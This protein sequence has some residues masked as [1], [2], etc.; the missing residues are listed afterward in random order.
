MRAEQEH[1][2]GGHE[3]GG[4]KLGGEADVLSEKT[5]LF[6]PDEF[7]DVISVDSFIE[8]INSTA[9]ELSDEDCPLEDGALDNFYQF[10]KECFNGFFEL[11]DQKQEGDQFLLEFSKSL[12]VL[13]RTFLYK[14]GNYKLDNPGLLT[15]ITDKVN[16]VNKEAGADLSY[17][18]SLF[19]FLSHFEMKNT[20]VIQTL[21]KIL[22]KQDFYHP[23]SSELKYHELDEKERKD[24]EQPKIDIGIA[25]VHHVLFGQMPPGF[26]SGGSRF[27]NSQLVTQ[28]DGGGYSLHFD[29]SYKK[30]LYDLWYLLRMTQFE[31][32]AVNIRMHGVTESG[33]DL[34]K[35][36]FRQTS[37]TV[38]HDRPSDSV[39]V[40]LKLASFRN[41]E[42]PIPDFQYDLVKL[43]ELL[44]EYSNSGELN[45]DI[46][47]KLSP[48]WKKNLESYFNLFLNFKQVKEIIMGIIGEVDA[49][50][51]SIDSDISK[52]VESLKNLGET[53]TFKEFGWVAR[54]T[55]R[56]A[57][58]VVEALKHLEDDLT[59]EK[60][61]EIVIKKSSNDELVVIEAL[62]HL[63]EKLTFKQAII[64]VNIIP[65]SADLALEVL[66]HLD[67]PLTFT[68]LMGW[69][70]EVKEIE[71]PYG[72]EFIAM[73]EAL[74][75]LKDDL[76]FEE[77]IEL[78]KEFEVESFIMKATKYLVDGIP[79]FEQIIEVLEQVEQ[80]TLTEK[81]RKVFGGRHNINYKLIDILA[82]GTKVLDKTL[83]F[84]QLLEL[85]KKSGENG[86]PLV[87]EALKRLK[88]KLTFEQVMT[89]GRKH[90]SYF[91][92]LVSRYVEYPMV[93]EALKHLEEGLT[94]DQ[95]I[96]LHQKFEKNGLLVSVSVEGLKHLANKLT[97]EQ[98]KKIVAKSK[99]YEVITEAL[100]HLKAKL[101]LE[102]IEIV[103]SLMLKHKPYHH[104]DYLA[105]IQ[106]LKNLPPLNFD[107]LK[108]IVNE[109]SENSEVD[110]H[111]ALTEALKHLAKGLTFKQA[112]EIIKTCLEDS[113]NPLIERREIMALVS[114]YL[115]DEPLTF[116]QM[117]ELNGL[118][119]ES[120]A[121]WL[122]DSYS[123]PEFLQSLKEPLT[124]E[125]FKSLVEKYG[126]S[127]NLTVELLEHLSGFN[128]SCSPKEYMKFLEDWSK[129]ELL[130]LSPQ[131]LRIFGPY[132]EPLMLDQWAQDKS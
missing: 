67:K 63:K 14:S 124:V 95:L 116:K 22:E 7:G 77:F 79:T 35:K 107:Q 92:H 33:L 6:S 113:F 4:R 48:F 75:H 109:V 59:F 69:A 3:L 110:R 27:W 125:Q 10:L 9:C 18:Q 43:I 90:R 105:A 56:N 8:V 123:I 99:N 31:V 104:V 58:V 5:G 17:L 117:I 82:E 76:T 81:I 130:Y 66:Q 115:N 132:N 19:D 118:N 55:W 86:S 120:V 64:I 26:E 72:E 88:D 61:I 70:N 108:M 60:F 93:I 91:A 85:Q 49:E 74:K 96:K 87:I 101:T 11:F 44:I 84:T 119:D 126:D 1:E 106:L 112:S 52:V 2:L 45:K 54:K 28:Y 128:D 62:K 127:W 73:T 16:L 53:L 12:D 68:Q 65:S 20:N 47:E 37:H 30:R 129:G 131:M 80:K 29:P 38:W 40:E 25:G 71:G 98:F 111:D 97:F 57:E 114:E 36:L 83:T 121:W 39:E 94:F 32:F 13:T 34:L 51:G 89:L 23:L 15:I 41:S 78:A 50:V 102:Q 103:W 100:K 122:K 21:L 46:L 24:V 42:V